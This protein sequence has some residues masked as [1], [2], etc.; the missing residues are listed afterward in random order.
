MFCFSKDHISIH[1][2]AN[3]VYFLTFTGYHENKIGKNDY[4]PNT[5]LKQIKYT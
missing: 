5:P 4:N 1:Q 2:K 3:V